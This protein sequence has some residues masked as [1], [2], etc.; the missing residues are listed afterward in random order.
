MRFLPFRPLS[1]RYAL[2]LVSSFPSRSRDAA[3]ISA[4]AQSA[5]AR[6]AE[7]SLSD[8]LASQTQLKSAHDA[9]RLE[10]DR[11]TAALSSAKLSAAALERDLAD[12]RRREEELKAATA[13][14]ESYMHAINAGTGT[15]VRLA[16][17]PL[18]HSQPSAST[19]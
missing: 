8:A 12:A 6:A 1:L 3:T 16:F 17:L 15:A 11:L 2:T 13:N 5:R 9:A 19:D 7:R 10:V 14:V 18:S 4:D